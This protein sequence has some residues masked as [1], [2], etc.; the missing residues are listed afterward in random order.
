MT[1]D[2]HWVRRWRR[3]IREVQGSWR[4]DA[5]PL[6][7]RVPAGHRDVAE[8]YLWVTAL[9]RLGQSHHLSPTTKHTVALT[10]S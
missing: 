10:G 1:G 4:G 3:W 2:D 7:H 9:P 6:E 5:A 8:G